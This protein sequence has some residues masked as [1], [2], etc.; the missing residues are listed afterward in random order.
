MTSG[1][2]GGGG[3]GDD[4]A[5]YAAL[6]AVS[7]QLARLYSTDPFSSIEALGP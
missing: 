7:A 6:N 1:G 4:A 5:N 2:G 3:G